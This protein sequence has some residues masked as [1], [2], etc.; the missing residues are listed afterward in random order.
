MLKRSSSFSVRRPVLL[1]ILI[2]AC[3]LSVFSSCSGPANLKIGTDTPA[4][5]GGGGQKPTDDN[6]PQVV[7]IDDQFALAFNELQWHRRSV[8]L[9]LN[10]T[11]VAPRLGCLTAVQTPVFLSFLTLT[12]DCKRT[13]DDA[14]SRAGRRFELN[15]DLIFS[16]GA[17][18]FSVDA[19]VLTLKTFALAPTERQVGLAEIARHLKL[20]G[21]AP[22]YRAGGDS[23]FTGGVPKLSGRLGEKWQSLF[24]ASFDVSSV[25]ETIAKGSF[26]TLSYSGEAAKDTLQK[27]QLLKLVADSPIHFALSADGF[28]LRP[29]GSFSWTLGQGGNANRGTLIAT[30]QGF[31][32]SDAGGVFR[33]WGPRCLEH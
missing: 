32:R 9:A 29:I 13:S 16:G 2:S 5:G 1:T 3:V 33:A 26:L 22:T 25:P 28:C 12:F 27:T 15:G 31:K 24:Q 10:P 6:T 20:V 14:D 21:T 8:E 11:S 4:G 19:D 7:T 30:N 23:T 17:G 18:D